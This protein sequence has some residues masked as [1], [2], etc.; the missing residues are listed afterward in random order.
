[1]RILVIGSPTWKNYNTVMRTMAVVLEEVKYDPAGDTH[2]AFVHTAQ[3]GAETMVTEFLGKS[4]RYLRQKGYF[5]KEEINAKKLTG[6]PLDKATAD[7][8]MITSGIDRAV[9]FLVPGDKRAESCL[10]IIREFD[11][12]TRLVKQ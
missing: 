2:I 5:V 9:V 3:R 1:M 4:E 8:D 11:I 6:N 7:Y 12:P 10:K